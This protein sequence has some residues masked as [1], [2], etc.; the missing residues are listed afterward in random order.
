MR[1]PILASPTWE[2]VQELEEIWKRGSCAVVLSPLHTAVE[3]DALWS[4]ARD[5]V[6]AGDALLLFTSGTTAKPKAARLTH[7]N[8]R[9]HAAVLHEAWRWTKDDRLVH[10]LP[11]H[12]LHGLGTALLTAKWAGAKIDL[13]PKFSPESVW[14]A[15]C[16]ATVYM[17]VPTTYAKLLR[18]FE[19][20]DANTR[21]RWERGARG[22]RLATNGSAAIP[23]SIARRWESIA[24]APPL[25]R[26]GMTEVGVVTS[27]SIDGPR[28]PGNSGRAVTGMEVRIGPEDEIEVRGRGVFPGYDDEA[29]NA[30]SFRDGW[31]RTGD[32]GALVDGD[33]FVHG[34]LSVDVLKS[35][36]YKLSALEIEAAIREHPAVEE[37]A[38]VG[39]PDEEW[40]D[41][42]TA[43]IVPRGELDLDA[44]RAFLRERLAPYKLPRRFV[45]RDSL[46]RNSIGKVTKPTLIAE[47]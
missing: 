25:E 16:D 10:A 37:V 18:A 2:F 28:V 40:G 19:D 46:P 3:R 13:L 11:L 42:V 24:G 17:G 41:L 34:R 45:I 33:L 4:A 27:Q 12:H 6:H 29:I 8:L 15:I 23:A 36:G 38:V 22:L 47:L 14:D 1:V 5:V 32:A 43:A 39:V 44:L 9:A 20:A 30:A 21:A 31:F 7:E 26:F 35:G